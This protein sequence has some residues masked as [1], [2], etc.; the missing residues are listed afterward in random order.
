MNANFD[1]RHEI[2]RISP[3][4]IKMIEVAR[5]TGASAKFSGS[6][7]AIVGTYKDEETYLRLG[8][9]F[10]PLNIQALKPVFVYPDD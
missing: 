10:K 8:E 3:R 4:N 2:Y 9:A 7:G 6:G 1:R 5:S